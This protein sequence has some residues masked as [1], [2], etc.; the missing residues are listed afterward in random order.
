MT[1]NI[2]MKLFPQG[3]TLLSVEFPFK[4]FLTSVLLQDESHIVSVGLERGK[5]HLFV[6][7]CEDGDLVS[8]IL[9]K[10]PG[11]K[12]ITRIVAVPGHN[13]L[14][15][16]GIID[17][18]K[19]TIMDVLNKKLVR[20]VPCWDGS[21]TSDGKYGLYAP[22]SGGM[23]ILDLRSG[24]VVRTLIPKIA[25]GIFDVIAMFTRTNEYVLYYHSG[26]KTIRLFRRKDG[27]QIANYRVSA[28]LKCLETTRDGRSVVLGMGDGAI[29]TL[30]IADLAK[31]DT[32]QYLKN[33]PSRLGF[34]RDSDSTLLP[35]LQNGNPYPNPYDFNIYTDYLKSLYSVVP[36]DEK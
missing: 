34:R 24:Q 32:K 33:L 30:T 36:N 12:D 13:R 3:D 9:P 17:M 5:C 28:E 11:V 29:T 22:A 4:K 8:K 2:K 14:G 6:W 27:V 10:Y 35:Y 31:S 15:H 23:D 1:G 25:E 18:E 26:R 19:G 16:V 21:F 7:R 20:T